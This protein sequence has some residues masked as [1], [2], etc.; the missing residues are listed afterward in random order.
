MLEAILFL[1]IAMLIVMP[2]VFI[3]LL[4]IQRLSGRLWKPQVLATAAVTITVVL[5]LG[6]LLLT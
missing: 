3:L 5:V 6:Y 1:F 4:G 2:V